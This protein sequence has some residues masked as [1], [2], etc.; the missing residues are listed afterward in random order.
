MYENRERLN[1]GNVPSYKE[2][3]GGTVY[4]YKMH[5]GGGGGGGDNFAKMQNITR[6]GYYIIYISLLYCG[7]IQFQNHKNESVQKITGRLC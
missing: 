6:F 4:T 2:H 5:P 3:P 7:I 1:G